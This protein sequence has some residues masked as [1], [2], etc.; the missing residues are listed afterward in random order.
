MKSVIL[1][2]PKFFGYS[3]A[4]VTQLKKLGYE[5]HFID[6]RGNNDIFTKAIY[7][8]RVLKWIFRPLIVRRRFVLIENLVDLQPSCVIF[9][10]P[11]YLRRSEIIRL[12]DTNISVLLYMWDS[13]SNKQAATSFLDTFDDVRSFDPVDVDCYKM[14]LLNL[15]A[16][17][18]F[19]IDDEVKYKREIDLSFVGTLHSD[20]VYYLSKIS[21]STNDKGLNFFVHGYNGNLFYHARNLLT[22]PLVVRQFGTWKSLAKE[23]VGE[24]FKSSKIVVDITHPDQHG[25]TSRSFEALASGAILLTTNL[26][27]PNILQDYKD[28]IVVF[29]DKNIDAKIGEALKLHE[30]KSVQCDLSYLGIARFCDELSQRIPVS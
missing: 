23:K 25:L 3:S 28:R 10:S 6:E 30:K 18:C 8:S 11:E 19:F 4:I 17:D 21:K 13:L 2:G 7:R 14:Q 20:R 9:I 29:N 27:A 5:A 16:E 1:V 24:V 26:N 15:F 22:T 12:Q